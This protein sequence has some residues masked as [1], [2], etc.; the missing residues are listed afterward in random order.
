MLFTELSKL[1]IEEKKSFVKES[2]YHNYLQ[3]LDLY[4]LPAFTNI[5]TKRVNS[6]LVQSRIYK[7]QTE[8]S[9]KNHYL[10][11]KTIVLIIRVLNQIIDFGIQNHKIKPFIYK[12]QYIKTK[13]SQT[14]LYLSE[15][16]QQKLLNEL[17]KNPN[18]N[19]L[20][21]L[22][23]YYEGLRIGEICALKWED[24]DFN[25]KEIY[26]NKTLEII[27]IRTK[28]VTLCKI[29][30]P[31]TTSSIRV[32]PVNKKIIDYIN[33]LNIEKKGYILTCTENFKKMTTLRIYFKRLC[34]KINISDVRF[35]CLRH[36]FASN[37][38]K[39]GANSKIV[40]ELLGHNSVATTLNIYVH[41]D[42]KEK[43]KYINSI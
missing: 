37:L 27:H 39:A 29:S 14:K 30:E 2:T 3:I 17:Y 9:Y 23:S 10:S 13:K 36:T 8:T 4:I 32:I 6:K 28:H 34:K 22:L 19:K 1:W 5:K 25:R 15:E 24:I 12:V 41:C 31:K 42:F 43:T 40:S 26:V 21:I 33:N 38:I 7:L 20:G 11:K 16:E 35:H 18:L